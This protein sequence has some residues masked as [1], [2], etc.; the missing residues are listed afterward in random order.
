MDV[1]RR[2][3][4][5][6]L[7]QGIS[8]AQ[9]AR[10]TGLSRPTVYLWLERAKESGF[11]ELAERSRRPLNLGRRGVSDE[12]QRALVEAKGKYPYWGAKKL[13]HKLW[14]DDP[15]CCLRT[16]DRILA[17]H[18]LV[19]ASFPADPPAITRF[20][21]A[22]PNE[23][24]QMDFKGMGNPRLPYSPL[25]VLD[26]ATRFALA[27]TPV[28]THSAAKVWEKLWIL[29][30]EYGLPEAILTDN[31]GCFA[32]NRGRG[33]GPLETWLWRLGIRTLQGRPRHPQTQGKVER[34]HRTVEL[35]LGPN[36]RQPDAELAIPYYKSFLVQYN[37]ERPHEAID[38]RVPGEL[39]RPSPR[40][41]P[42]KLPPAEIFGEARKVDVSGM[43]TFKC[44]R[45]RVGRGLGGELVDI[46]DENVFY[47]KVHLGPLQ[48]LEV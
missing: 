46:R 20:E 34:F 38:M 26:D 36:L 48:E 18:G 6:V 31:E 32:S 2:A 4:H 28:S 37:W 10:E 12:I 27:F 15:P 25:S 7:K 21:R 35:E 29:F 5:L 24:W 11:A 19:G 1:R 41:R 30:G 45:Y 42:D 33:P 47:A 43:F 13:L 8:V 44:K 22:L 39:Y 3:V 9:A 40:P 16:A 23:L 17:R 14:G